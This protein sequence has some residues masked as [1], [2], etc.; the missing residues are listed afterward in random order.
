MKILE[1]ERWLKGTNSRGVVIP[2]TT[3]RKDGGYPPSGGLEGGKTRCIREREDMVA[4][5]GGH[6]PFKGGSPYLRPSRH[7]LSLLQHTP[8]SSPT[9]RGLGP[10]RHASRL[11]AEEAKP[12]RAVRTTAQRLQATL[13]F[14][15]RPAGERVGSHAGGMQPCQVGALLRLPT[16]PAWRPRPTRHAIG[17]PNASC[18]QLHRHFRHHR[19][20][21]TAEPMPRLEAAQCTTQ[22]RR[23]GATVNAAKNGPP[24][25]AVAGRQEQRSRHQPS[26]RPVRGQRENPLSR[27][28]GNAP[29][30]RSSNGSRTHNGRPSN[31]SPRR[32]N[33]AAGQAAPLA[34]EAGD[35][36]P[37]P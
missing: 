12:P 30:I 18:M 31:H 16:R 10:T 33:S 9:A 25:M 19:A 27:H 23:P 36:S 8:R 17:A 37:S 6:P 21:S 2:P 20:S 11:R 22:R 32:I 34:G 5:Q 29:V 24:V 13:H 4:F 35:A 15:P 14:L 26:S 3:R 1:A 7:G 28:E